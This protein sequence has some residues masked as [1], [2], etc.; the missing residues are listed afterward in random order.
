MGVKMQKTIKRR[1]LTDYLRAWRDYPK[2]LQ[3]KAV[4]DR[5]HPIRSGI[6]NTAID[7]GC[8]ALEGL[9]V[10]GIA[11]IIT[12]ALGGIDAFK[13]IEEYLSIHTGAP[14]KVH[15]GYTGLI[16]VIMGRSAQTKAHATKKLRDLGFFKY[17]TK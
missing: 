4:E 8:R 11:Y 1:S 6:K 17:P 14:T 7:W 15:A 12:D 2:T 10:G 5:E 9:V 13:G 16:A 3:D